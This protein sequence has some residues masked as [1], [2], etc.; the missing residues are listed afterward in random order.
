MENNKDLTK[1]V[2]ELGYPLLETAQQKGT[3]EILA[4]VVKSR[5][6]RLWQGF[7]V[8]LAHSEERNVFDYKRVLSLL[9][10]PDER[11]HYHRL[12]LVS[13]VL[14]KIQ[15]LKSAWVSDLY[16][17]LGPSDKKEIAKLLN[18]FV[19][20]EYFQLGSV[21]LSTEKIKT[22]FQ[23]YFEKAGSRMENI[24]SVREEFG[25]E[26]SLAQIF[27]PAQKA[28]IF[29]KLRREKLSKTEKEY[30]SRVVKKKLSALANPDLHRL[31]RRL[32]E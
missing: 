7:P 13:Y 29:K 11:N 19:A 22:V 25:V 23:D 9:K 2:G 28:L 21:R 24:L 4:A 1:R 20:K 10:A 3:N 6:A 8:M 26:Y 31:A 14:Y 5:D 32:I 17:I 16:K 18:Q 30:F 27:P 12:L 15:N